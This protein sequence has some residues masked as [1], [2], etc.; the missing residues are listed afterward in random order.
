MA[1]KPNCYKCEHRGTIPGNCHST[2]SAKG[3]AVQGNAHGIRSGWFIWP[4]N[5]DP[6]WL[7][8]CDS[9]KANKEAP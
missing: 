4:A 8:S 2:C 5:F 6:T 9:F 3:A 1:D 7:E